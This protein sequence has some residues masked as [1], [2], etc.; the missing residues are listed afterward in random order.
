[1]GYRD[2]KGILDS[3]QFCPDWGRVSVPTTETKNATLSIGLQR[4]FDYS[5]FYSNVTNMTEQCLADYS[6]LS[7]EGYQTNG[8][9]LPSTI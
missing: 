9:N 6:S 5:F 3:E 2:L 7:Y 4:D 8:E 1:M